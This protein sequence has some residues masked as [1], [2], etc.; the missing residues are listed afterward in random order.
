MELLLLLMR[1]VSPCS[2]ASTRRS[3]VWMLVL[4][5]ALVSSFIVDELLSWDEELQ[6]RGGGRSTLYC[7]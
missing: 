7:G 4:V 2:N 6:M 3:R 5:D 1:F